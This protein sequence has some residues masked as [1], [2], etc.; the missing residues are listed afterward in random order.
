MNSNFLEAFFNSAIGQKQFDRIKIGA[1]MG[2]LSQEAVKALRIPLP[3]LA[4]QKEIAERI[5][6]IRQDAQ[7]LKD[8]TKEA[9]DKASKEIEKILLS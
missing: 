8:K 5:T 2:S 9:L 3:P 7:K 1:I 4:K 6:R